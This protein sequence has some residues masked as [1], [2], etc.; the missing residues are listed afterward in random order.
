MVWVGY[1]GSGCT[2]LVPQNTV[3]CTVPRPKN[4]IITR[5]QS[6]KSEKKFC[7]CYLYFTGVVE[8][9]KSLLCRPLI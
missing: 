8:T 7:H 3:L 4:G 6:V 9:H 2:T 5:T 1:P